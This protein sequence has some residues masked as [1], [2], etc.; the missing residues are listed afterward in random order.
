MIPNFEIIAQPNPVVPP[1]EPRSPPL[2]EPSAPGTAPG[3]SN[4]VQY[5]LY[6]Y[7][8]YSLAPLSPHLYALAPPPPNS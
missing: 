6:P 3:A 2:R 4:L 8:A 5:L 7:P 1:R